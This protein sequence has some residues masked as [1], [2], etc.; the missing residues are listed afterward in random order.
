MIDAKQIVQVIAD[1]DIEVNH[2]SLEPDVDLTEQG[3][4]SLDMA[5]LLFELEEKFSVSVEDDDLDAGK[6]SS[7][8]KIVAYV[9]DKT[10]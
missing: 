5:T 7:I 3:L 1:S 6:L 10:A 8:A 4:D 9:N 2:E